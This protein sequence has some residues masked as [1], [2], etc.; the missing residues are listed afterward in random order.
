M[1]GGSR[2]FVSADVSVAAVDTDA[3]AL[4]SVPVHGDRV[5]QRHTV[6]RQDSAVL[7]A[8]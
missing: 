4:R 5:D 1:R 3:S 2:R 8:R 6:L 7:Y